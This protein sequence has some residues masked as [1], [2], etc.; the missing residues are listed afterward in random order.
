MI[1]SIARVAQA[2][3]QTRIKPGKSAASSGRNLFFEGGAR[4]NP[5]LLE[6]MFSGQAKADQ[7]NF[8]RRQ[9]PV[10]DKWKGYEFNA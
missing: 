1:S 5:R 10:R 6:G 9:R 3:T 7:Q 4:V 2:L 8:Q